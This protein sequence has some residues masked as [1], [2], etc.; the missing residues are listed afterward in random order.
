VDESERFA[1]LLLKAISLRVHDQVSRLALLGTASARSRLAERLL[2]F[3]PLDRAADAGEVRVELPLRQYELAALLAIT[4]EYLSRLL[5][6]FEE[7]G[8][9]RRKSG[10][11][12]IRSLRRLVQE[13]GSRE[14]NFGSLTSWGGDTDKGQG[15]A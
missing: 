11:I 13:V 1:R 5:K 12:I 15:Q 3:V 6:E 8:V 14:Q 4:P 10:W 9:I 7:A 2:Q